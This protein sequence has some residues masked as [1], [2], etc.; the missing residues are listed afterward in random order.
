MPA[1]FVSPVCAQAMMIATGTVMMMMM[2]RRIHLH[3]L[4][5]SLSSLAVA[6]RCVRG[7]F[8]FEL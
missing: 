5:F 4:R 8:Q 2:M 1:W 7:S 6:L 3:L